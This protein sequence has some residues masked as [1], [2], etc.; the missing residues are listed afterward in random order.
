MPEPKALIATGTEAVSG[1]IYPLGK[2]PATP[3][4]YIGG[5]PPR[6]DVMIN[7]FRYLMGKW[8]FSFQIEVLQRILEMRATISKESSQ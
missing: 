8:K 6:P 7:G 1:G 4:L 2:L 3:D 5:D